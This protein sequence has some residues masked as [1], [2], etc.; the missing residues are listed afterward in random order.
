MEDVFLVQ[1]IVDH[2][3]VGLGH[4]PGIV[5]HMRLEWN[6]SLVLADLGVGSSAISVRR[7]H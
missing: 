2:I 3:C 1:G 4:G 5:Q 7:L 6:K